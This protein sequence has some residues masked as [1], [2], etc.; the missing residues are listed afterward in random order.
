MN[1]KLCAALSLLTMT[2]A[3]PAWA[4]WVKVS[5]ASDI[6]VLIDPSSI[7]KNEH[8][9]RVWSLTNY[10][11]D[12]PEGLRSVRAY[13]EYDCNEE[14]LRELS[15]TFFSEPMGRGKILASVER[16]RDWIHVAPDT[17]GRRTLT[18]VCAI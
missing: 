10:K 9:R 7:R 18:I 1:K 2:V 17:F 16:P 3:A 5:D 15:L 12:G 6:E 8:R 13:E 14:R 11:Q 4:E